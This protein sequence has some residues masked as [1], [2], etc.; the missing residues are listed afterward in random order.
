[1]KFL[2]KKSYLIGS[3]VRCGD[4]SILPAQ[5]LVDSEIWTGCAYG[6]YYRKRTPRQEQIALYRTPCAYYHA[7]FVI[8]HKNIGK[9]CWSHKWEILLRCGIV[10]NTESD[11]EKG[12]IAMV[13]KEELEGYILRLNQIVEAD[14]DP[15]GQELSNEILAVVESLAEL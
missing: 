8:L 1:M 4:A 5:Y 12:S 13:P 2:K 11:F 7:T 3:F 6:T 14:D 9:V 15:E 10:A